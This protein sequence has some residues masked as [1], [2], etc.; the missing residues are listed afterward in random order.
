MLAIMALTLLAAPPATRI[1]NVVDKLHGVE[2][3]DPYRWLEHGDSAEVKAWTAAQNRYLREH[4]DGF[5]G[6]AWLQGRLAEWLQTGTLGTPVM[7]G[8]GKQAR[9]FY[10]RRDGK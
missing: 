8:A 7:R 3:R 10:T 9:L 1:E 2:V 5:P 6:R 4:L